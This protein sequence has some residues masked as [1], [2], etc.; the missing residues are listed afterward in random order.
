VADPVQQQR[1]HD[2]QVQHG[3]PP[4][5]RYRNTTSDAPDPNHR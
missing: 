1:E 4:P 2:Q 5:N 3:E